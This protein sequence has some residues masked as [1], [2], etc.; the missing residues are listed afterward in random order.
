MSWN[1]GIDDVLIVFL[2]LS[3]SGVIGKNGHVMDMGNWRKICSWAPAV[4]PA[5]FCQ[6]VYRRNCIAGKKLILCCQMC[7]ILFVIDFFP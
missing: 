7:R 5:F 6:N 3:G 1:K 2:T 4:F